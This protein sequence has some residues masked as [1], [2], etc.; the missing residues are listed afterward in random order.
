MGM[1]PTA[2]ARAAAG[3][4]GMA[5]LAGMML[6][7]MTDGDLARA[8]FSDLTT[9]L[10][11]LR[12]PGP[13]DGAWSAPALSGQNV[14]HCSDQAAPGVARSIRVLGHRF[15]RS[16]GC[17]LRPCGSSG[18]QYVSV[19]WGGLSAVTHAGWCALGRSCIAAGPTPA[20]A[21]GRWCLQESG[22]R[23][24]VKYRL[25]PAGWFSV[26]VARL[27]AEP[28]P[29]AASLAADSGRRGCRHQVWIRHLL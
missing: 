20:V 11:G 7:L 26:G 15:V 10:P 27:L 21:L 4:A 25:L 5:V 17:V 3:R 2:G 28:V 18:D 29:A 1:V 22:N 16:A 24:A 8:G 19:R 9:S 14:L 23:K 13:G 6:K 12:G